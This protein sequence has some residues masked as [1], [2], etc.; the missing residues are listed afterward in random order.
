[1]HRCA[2]T[3]ICFALLMQEILQNAYP[4]AITPVGYAFAIWGIIFLLE[5]GGVACLSGPSAGT[6]ARNKKE[7]CAVRAPWLAMWTCQNLWQ[8][9]FVHTPLIPPTPYSSLYKIFVPCSILL[10]S[11]L[12]AG[13]TACR[14]LDSAGV[15]SHTSG[16]FV[17]LASAINT[18]WLSAASC[19]GLALV[20]QCL[21]G[22]PEAFS[23][24]IAPLSL[25]SAA[26]VG[27]LVFNDAHTHFL[28]ISLS[29]SLCL[30]I[31]RTNTQTRIHMYMYL[32][33]F[34]SVSLC[35]H[36]HKYV[37]MYI[38]TYFYIYI[39][40]YVYIYSYLHIK[41]H[42]CIYIHAYIC[43]YIQIKIT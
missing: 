34:L 2:H 8:I 14:R 19:I 42:I 9:V 28:Y 23:A 15:H 29:L 35:H 43:T 38:C 39:Y 26:T 12:A 10:L 18:G 22:S 37:L 25:A 31:S 13:L 7:M 20:G 21:A 4:T 5:G 24:S 30:C 6:S 32:F 40:F 33:L 41:R 27:A 36:I 17:A 3:H 16:V 11:S 1:M